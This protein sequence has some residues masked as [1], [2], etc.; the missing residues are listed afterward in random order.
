MKKISTRS[1][2]MLK[3]DRIAKRMVKMRACRPLDLLISRIILVTLSTRKIRI[4]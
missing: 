4:I 2:K 3:R 1:M